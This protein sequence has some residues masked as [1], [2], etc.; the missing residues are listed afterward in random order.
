MIQIRSKSKKELA[1][2]KLENAFACRYLFRSCLIIGTDKNTQGSI[3]C[4]SC[5]IKIQ[6]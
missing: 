2:S 6:V 4:P 1:N 3:L 5:Q